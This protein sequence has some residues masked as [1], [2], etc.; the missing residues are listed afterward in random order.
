MTDWKPISTAPVG[1]WINA[2]SASG[3]TPV[4]VIADSEKGFWEDE[5]GDYLADITIVKGGLTEWSPLPNDWSVTYQGTARY[6]CPVHTYERAAVEKGLDFQN[7]IRA[8][9]LE[10]HN[11]R[12]KFEYSGMF[13]AKNKEKYERLA[14]KYPDFPA[15]Y[16]RMKSR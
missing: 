1:A 12:Q 14:E 6:G 8:R 15:A 3:K 11:I 5:T 9:K 7:Y 13:A 10:Q 16:E 4:A 2:R